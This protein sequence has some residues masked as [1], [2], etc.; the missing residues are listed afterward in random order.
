MHLR[1]C[2]KNELCPPYRPCVNNSIVI[3]PSQFYPV[4]AMDSNA[5]LVGQV[6]NLLKSHATW[7]GFII[8]VSPST[9]KLLK[10]Y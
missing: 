1:E 4:L 7:S 6:V 10:V 2:H 5:G 8:A 9:G 3:N